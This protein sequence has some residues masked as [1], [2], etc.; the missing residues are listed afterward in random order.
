M[1]AMPQDQPWEVV[2]CGLEDLLSTEVLPDTS[3]ILQFQIGSARSDM[4]EDSST[5]PHGAPDEVVRCGVDD[6]LPWNRVPDTWRTPQSWGVDSAV[7]TYE[8]SR[9]ELLGSWDARAAWPDFG[10]D[11]RLPWDGRSEASESSRYVE[12]EE[13]SDY[14]L[15]Y[16]SPDMPSGVPSMLDTFTALANAVNSVLPHTVSLLLVGLACMTMAFS[17]EHE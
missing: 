15:V 17:P 10:V 16:S 12:A 3:Q 1:P 9:G 6:L 8:S 4:E 14:V 7:P 13:G 11:D 2:R 5:Q